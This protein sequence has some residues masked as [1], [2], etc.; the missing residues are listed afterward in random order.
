M[1]KNEIAK[2]RVENK[3]KR[4]K[5][6]DTFRRFPEREFIGVPKDMALDHSISHFARSILL[7]WFAQ[8]DDSLT[9]PLIMIRFGVTSELAELAF[10]EIKE[11]AYV[12]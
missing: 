1:S 10:N 12:R 8:K 5:V 6:P 2:S 3:Q 9:V 11:T 7:D 4:D